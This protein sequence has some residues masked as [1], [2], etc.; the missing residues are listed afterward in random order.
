[1]LNANFYTPNT[2]ECIPSGEIHSVKNTPFDLTK[3]TKFFN[4]LNSEFEQI[5][6]FNGFDHNFVLRGEGFRKVGEA[7]S[8]DETITMEVFTDLPGVQLY[9][10]NALKEGKYKNGE[11]YGK[12]NAF[13]LETQL[14]PNSPNFSHFDTPLLKSD[15]IMYT[16]TEYK[17]I[18]K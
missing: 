12:H 3:K 5:K 17:F 7:T 18:A 15:E 9:T 4:V 14:F 13:C 2:T 6:M 16:A 8:S 10:A 11:K 1:M